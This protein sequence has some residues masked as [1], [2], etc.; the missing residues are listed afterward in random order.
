V[1]KNLG[2]DDHILVATAGSV[3]NAGK[4][5][6]RAFEETLKS[7]NSNIEIINPRFEPVIGALLLALKEAG[8]EINNKVL[9]NLSHNF[10]I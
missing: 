2:L 9:E 4:T 8:I 6:T 10:T 3:F 7:Y 1:I 5:L